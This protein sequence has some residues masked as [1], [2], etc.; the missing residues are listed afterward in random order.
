[1]YFVD[2]RDSYCSQLLSPDPIRPHNPGFPPWRVF[3][4]HGA[5]HFYLN[6]VRGIAPSTLTSLI[7]HLLRVKWAPKEL[8]CYR[9]LTGV[10]PKTSLSPA[11]VCCDIDKDMG[12]FRPTEEDKDRFFAVTYCDVFSLCID[13]GQFV[14]EPVK[15]R[16]KHTER[17]HL[18][19]L[20]RAPYQWWDSDEVNVISSHKGCLKSNM[21]SSLEKTQN[22]DRAE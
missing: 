11:N 17:K 6:P 16:H 7:A 8:I 18:G 22:I 15:F 19:N 3:L 20:S 12:Y 10:T 2:H 14:R 21:S 4:T 1:M 9:G 13:V 5:T